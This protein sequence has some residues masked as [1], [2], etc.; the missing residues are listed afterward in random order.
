MASIS[1]DWSPLS[2]LPLMKKVGVEFTPSLLGGAVAHL[3][4]AVEHLLIRQALVEGLL[5]EAELLGDVAQR[6][7]RRFHHPFALLGEQASRPP[8]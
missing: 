7:D 5:G 6:R 1:I 3:L 2:F 8:A 4:D